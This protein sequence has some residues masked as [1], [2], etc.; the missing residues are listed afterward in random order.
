M[1][2][3]IQLIGTA[4]TI[5]LATNIIIFLI[6]IL[7]GGG[8]LFGL[9]ISGGGYAKDFGEL[10]WAGVI[11]NHEWWRL[12]TCGYLHLG[13]FHLAANIFALLAIGGI[14]EKQIG[15]L[16]MFLAYHIGTAITALIWCLIFQNASMVGASLGIFDLLGIY[17]GERERESSSDIKRSTRERNYLIS[18][19]VISSLL[20][21]KTIAVHGIGFCLGLYYTLFKGRKSHFSGYPSS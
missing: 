1:K 13:I 7:A 2:T 19:A 17:V 18:Y 15:S 12:F 8:S 10:T 3:K 4:T 6:N 16:H 9:F 21:I 14:I 5:I 20:G 11:A